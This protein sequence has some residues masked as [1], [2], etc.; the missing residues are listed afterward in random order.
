V[1]AAGRIGILAGGSVRSHNAA[2]L[3]ARTGATELHSRTPPDAAAVR[4]LVD[5]ANAAPTIS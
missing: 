5:A 2:A 3:V 4:A 1:Q